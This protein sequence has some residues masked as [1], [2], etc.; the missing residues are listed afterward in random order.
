MIIKQSPTQPVQLSAYSTERDAAGTSTG[1]EHA[2]KFNKLGMAHKRD[3]KEY[4]CAEYLHQNTYS[5][6]DK[7]CE[8]QQYRVAQP[9]NKAPDVEPKFKS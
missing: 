7:E 8:L 6:Y 5:Y 3:L 2:L 4:K 9:T 1:I